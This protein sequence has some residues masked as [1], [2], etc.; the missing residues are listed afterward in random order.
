MLLQLMPDEKLDP[1][2]RSFI[3]L[4]GNILYLFIFIIL[5]FATINI[6]KRLIAYLLRHD[7]NQYNNYDLFCNNELMGRDYSMAFI[8]KTRWRNRPLS[9]PLLL[10]Y[11]EHIDF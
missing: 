7:I 6:V 3:R 5:G 11:K 8:Q 1:L 4:S 10:I 9:E 2:E